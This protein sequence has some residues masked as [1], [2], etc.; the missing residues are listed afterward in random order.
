MTKDV[1]RTARYLVESLRCSENL[2]GLK[3]ISET[4]ASR[5][6]GATVLKATFAGAELNNAVLPVRTKPSRL[7]RIAPSN[8]GGVE[9][10]V[11]DPAVKEKVVGILSRGLTE[12]MI[13][14]CDMKPQLE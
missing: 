11:F 8:F 6:T 1:N 13:P 14:P 9:V 12:G 5:F 2:P 10:E 7:L 4:F 3:D